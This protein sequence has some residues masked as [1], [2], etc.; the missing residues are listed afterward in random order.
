MVKRKWEN[1][2]NR[3]DAI[4]WRNRHD[5]SLTIEAHRFNEENAK[6]IGAN[7]YVFPAKNGKGIPSSPELVTTKKDAIAEI[8]KLK[9]VI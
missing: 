5:S 9:K 8:Q 4:I 1:I 6:E 2:E 7:W 3:K